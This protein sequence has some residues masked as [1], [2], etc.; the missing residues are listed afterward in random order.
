MRRRAAIFAV[1]A[2][3]ASPH[4]L[5]SRPMPIPMVELYAMAR[6]VALV[7]VVEGRVVSAGGDWCGAR[8]VGRVIEGV[9]NAKPGALIEFGYV[10]ELKIGAAYLVLLGDFNDAPMERVPDFET[11]C[12]AALPTA[13]M[14]QYWRGAM[15]V[16]GDTRSAAKRSTWT[17]RRVGHVTYPLG[18]RTV[19]VDG[20]KQF[21]YADLTS[22]M[23]GEK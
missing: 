6:T 11:R 13:T 2:G 7:E 20:E 3:V 10:P 17:V 18:T 8:Y 5:A 15:E 9:K 21:V 14:V 23:T 19:V 22:R 4:L 16:V 12:K 1:G